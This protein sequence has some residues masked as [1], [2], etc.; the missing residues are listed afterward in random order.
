MSLF[1]CVDVRAQHGVCYSVSPEEISFLVILWALRNAPIQ[2]WPFDSLLTFHPV[3][4]RT[5]GHPEPMS[6]DGNQSAE[7]V[8][9]AA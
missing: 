8:C 3:P 5:L 6:P 1:V 2:C 7:Q 4:C 9:A